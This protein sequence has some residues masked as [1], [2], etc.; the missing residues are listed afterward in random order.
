MDFCQQYCH[1]LLG[2][3]KGIRN[4]WYL[5]S[6]IFWFSF[7]LLFYLDGMFA[8]EKYKLLL[9]WLVKNN[10]HQTN[11]YF[12][13]EFLQAIYFQIKRAKKYLK[14][15]EI[16]SISLFHGACFLGTLRFYD[17]SLL[18]EE[19]QRFVNKFESH[20]F[21]VSWSEKAFLFIFFFPSYNANINKIYTK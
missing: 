17:K 8:V 11:T 2:Y 7:Y 6:Y 4:F 18:C 19:I 5:V 1:I 9:P 14:K 10:M 21:K 16:T 13:D 12:C 15:F 20:Q 3:N